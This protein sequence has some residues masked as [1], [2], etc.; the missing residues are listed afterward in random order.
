MED[1]HVFVN[2]SSHSSWTEWFAE[3]KGLQDHELRGI[4]S[5]F[6]NTQKLMLEHSEG[7]SECETAWQVHLLHGRDQYCLIIQW[8]KAKVRVYSDSVLCLRKL[9]GSEGAIERWKGQ[10]EE[11]KIVP[12][13]QRTI[14]NRRRSNWIRVE[15]FPWIFVLKILQEIQHDLERKNIKFGEFTGRIIFKSMF[16]D[17]DWT[18]E[19]MMRIVFRMQK[20]SGITRRDSCK[21]TGRFQVLDR[22]RSGMEDL[23]TFPMENGTPQPMKWYSDSKKQ[24]VLYF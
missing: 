14:W 16:S 20:M 9:N 6:N 3:P 24:V 23:L 8:E 19:E 15:D 5:L 1:V 7:V 17:I 10:V 18:K 13:L 11:F 4:Q 22:K 21:D 12:F 2:E